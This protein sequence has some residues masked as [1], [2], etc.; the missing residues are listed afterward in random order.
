VTEEETIRRASDGEEDAM[1][2]L[3]DQYAPFV[4][5]VVRRFTRDRPT[6]RDWEQDAWI[7]IFRSLP[8]FRGDAKLSSWL[9]RVVVNTVLQARRRE[10]RFDHES[11]DTDRDAMAREGQSADQILLRVGL[12][13]ALAQLPSGMH[14]ILTLHDVHGFQHEEIATMLDITS[15][16]SRSQLFKARARL[17]ELLRADSSTRSTQ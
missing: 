17:R 15:G 11:Y 4:F 13:D 14:A 10:R 7:S 16:A 5:T 2:A 1:R 8:S 3:Y 12:Q 6:A 9:H